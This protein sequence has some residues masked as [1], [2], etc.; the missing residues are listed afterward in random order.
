MKTIRFITNTVIVVIFSIGMLTAQNNQHYRIHVDYVY[1]SSSDAYEKV[2]K[3]LADLAKENK[4]EKGWNVLWTNDNRV[5]SISPIGGWEEMGDEFMPNTRAKLGDEKF[6]EIFEE[7]DNHYDQH[8]DYIITLSNN[9]SY[10]PDGMTTTPEGQNYRKNLVMYHKARDRQ[11]IA[12]IAQKYKDLYTEK[13]SKSHYRLYFSGFGN[14]ESYILVSY[15]SESPLDH[16][17]KAEANR[18]LIG[19][20]GEKMWKELSK[21]I[22]KIEYTEGNMVP[23]L[24]YNPSKS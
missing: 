2:S 5:V 10:M 21:Y 8:N 4:E 20:E 16:A 19:E 11:K 22:T 13:G 12:E 23:E 15:A 24:S 7:F 14:P 17:N 3:R 1:P 6:G 9:L 18:E